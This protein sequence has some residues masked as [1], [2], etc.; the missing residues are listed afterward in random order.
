MF[1]IGHRECVSLTKVSN[2]LGA[3]VH[4]IMI[5][6]AIVYACSDL[7]SIRYQGS[8]C[9]QPYSDGNYF[10]ST[11]VYNIMETAMSISKAM[12]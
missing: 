8:S 3:V 10:K 12:G 1:N 6:I 5:Y 4:V 7:L 2:T 11:M 9:N